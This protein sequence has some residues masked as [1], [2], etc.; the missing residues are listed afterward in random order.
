MGN[1]YYLFI[2]VVWWSVLSVKTYCLL[3][4]YVFNIN[5]DQTMQHDCMCMYDVTMTYVCYIAQ[6]IETTS[7]IL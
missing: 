6:Q 1:K 2:I 5:Y 7:L 3:N 4:D